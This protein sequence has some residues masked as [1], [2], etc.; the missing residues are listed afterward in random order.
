MK[1]YLAAIQNLWPDAWGDN[2]NHTLTK[3]FGFEIMFGVFPAAKLRC[4]LNNGRQ[5]TA[6]NFETQ[7]EPLKSASI[8]LPGGGAIRMDWGKAMGVINN[9]KTRSLI[10]KQM[11]D[12]LARADEE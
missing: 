3:A 4:D 6:D 10:V 9:A 5:Y 12:I 8:D 7:M 2:K 11:K 1:A